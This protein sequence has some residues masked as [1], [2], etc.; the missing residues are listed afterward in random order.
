MLPK[1]NISNEWRHQSDVAHSFVQFREH[2]K[3]FRSTGHLFRDGRW[4]GVESDFHQYTMAE[5]PAFGESRSF[6]G[7]AYW[8][9]YVIPP[10]DTESHHTY[11]WKPCI[12]R[13]ITT[14]ADQVY[15]VVQPVPVDPDFRD[16]IPE[17]NSDGT[18]F[19]RRYRPGNPVANLGQ[20][21]TELRELPQLPIFLQ[22]RAKKFQD[23]GGEYL[24]VEF[25]WLPFLDDV[26]KLHGLQVSIHKRL[27]KLVKENGLSVRKRSKVLSNSSPALV[28]DGVYVKPFGHLGDTGLGGSTELEG[29][30]S[31]GPFPYWDPNSDFNGSCSY[32][33]THTTSS[34]SWQIG[35]FRYYVP[36][37][38]SDRWTVKA[39]Q[40]MYGGEVTPSMI[41]QVIPW[42]WLIDWF[43]NVGDIL[44]NLQT[45]AV[46]NETLTNAYAMVTKS[47]TR[48]VHA[49]VGWEELNFAP[50]NPESHLDVHAHIPAG[51]SDLIYVFSEVEK[52]RRQ[53]TPF[54]FGYD[55]S[56]LTA[57]Q[58]AILAALAIS[59]GR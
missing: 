23:L 30:H 40:V 59:R 55:M 39:M 26:R 1:L 35:T 33:V 37:I 15:E 20:F 29:V 58:A 52:L 38:G 25:G 9:D 53:A 24:N 21:I 47:V 57:K 12:S 31:L 2:K 8:L 19:I 4:E 13:N 41:W 17:L 14:S 18:S 54:G 51:E 50:F 43:A 56:R 27:A 16:S 48:T 7:S 45:S 34:V 22:R 5:S 28:A 3:L 42:G 36:D 6:D 11:N 10:L 46:D 49:R 44:H 32:I